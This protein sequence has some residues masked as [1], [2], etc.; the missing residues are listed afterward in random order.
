MDG[1][2]QASFQ[3]ISGE[4]Q[5]QFQHGPSP[6]F[7]ELQ[8]QMNVGHQNSFNEWPINGV[9]QNTIQPGTFFLPSRQWRGRDDLFCC[10]DCQRAGKDFNHNWKHCKDMRRMGQFLGGDMDSN[11]EAGNASVLSGHQ[12]L[13]NQFCDVGLHFG[14]EQAIFPPENACHNIS[15]GIQQWKGG[16][17]LFSCWDCERNGRDFHHNWQQCK[18]W[19]RS[20]G[21]RA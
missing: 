7:F 9:C 2:H 19:R 21:N 15:G 17:D 13:D 20:M 10:W 4:C 18:D 1:E 14:A 16:Y 8:G 11:L 5:S 6:A 12:I 3:P